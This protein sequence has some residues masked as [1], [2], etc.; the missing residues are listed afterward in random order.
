MKYKNPRSI[1]YSPLIFAF[2]L[3]LGIF[4]GNLL[5][6][7]QYNEQ[8]IVYPQS[9]KLNAILDLIEED[10]VDKMSK[11]ELV[12][13]TIPLLLKELD[14][15]SVYIPAEELQRVQE[16]LN[17]NFEGIGVQFNVHND[18]ILV[19][20]VIQGGPSAKVGLLPGD[21][22]VRI[23]DSLFVG[24]NIKSDDVISHLKGQGGTKVKVGIARR[25]D[26]GLIDFIITRGKIPIYSVDVAYMVNDE[27]GYIK[28]NR[29]ARTTYHEFIDGIR[30][31]KSQGMKKL[32]VD[33]RSNTG[34]YLDAATSI[35]DEFLSKGKM[36]V[37]TQ[38]NNRRK[39]EYY[40]KSGG[41]CLDVKV[42]VLQDMYSASASEI[43]AGALQDNDVG[44]IIGQRSYGKGLVQEPT[45]FPDS[46]AIRLTIARYYTPTGRCIQKSYKNGNDDY[47][48]D[49][50]H[51]YAHGEFMEEDSVK[52]EDSLK[53][54]TPKGKTV[55]GG[56]GIMPDIF[57][58]LDTTGTS[59]YLS[60]ITRQGL[61]YNFAL[62]YS[63]NERNNLK[64]LVSY[65]EFVTYL[66][67][68]DILEQFINYANRK[69]VERNN[70]EVEIS[71]EIIENRIMAYITRN[72]I[73]NEGFY[74][75]INKIDNVFNKA[76]EEFSENK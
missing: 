30:K 49:L 50:H 6:S 17:G 46:S 70:A 39:E 55:Y 72:I 27:T 63:D 60:K 8:F 19:I 41:S 3:V 13:K 34:G 76:M 4:L 16:P 28:I 43:L 5:K 59:E 44:I 56:G 32:I 64:Q 48:A 11:E 9:N 18:T 15:H 21:R 25:G 26:D 38:G 37:Y 22:I 58:P 51:R 7:N 71:K 1:I 74:P 52:F 68:V 29:F 67:S 53:Y 65:D 61:I 40:A 57:V 62:D 20:D 2:V 33:L 66:R 42:A 23:D 54:I 14:P 10:Y 45:L 69:G 24:P 47:F 75:I 31:L 35:A 12:E 73:D 36:I